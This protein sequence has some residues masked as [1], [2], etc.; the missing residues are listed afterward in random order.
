MSTSG[1]SSQRVK[2]LWWNPPDQRTVWGTA[3]TF[4]PLKR[5]PNTHHIPRGTQARH[6][7]PHRGAFRAAP[8]TPTAPQ[9]LGLLLLGPAAHRQRGVQHQAGGSSVKVRDVIPEACLRTDRESDPAQASRAVMDRFMCSRARVDEH[10]VR[11]RARLLT[12]SGLCVATTAWNWKGGRQRRQ[13][14]EVRSRPG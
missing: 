6:H 2:P 5:A 12:I 9:A 13:P 3:W 8:Q 4:G 11:A 1:R 14:G 7:P 10:Q